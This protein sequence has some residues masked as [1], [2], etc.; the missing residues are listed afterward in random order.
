MHWSSVTSLFVSYQ[1]TPVL[2]SSLRGID[3]VFLSVSAQH[4]A[5]PLDLEQT[6]AERTVARQ[7]GDPRFVAARVDASSADDIATL[8][9]NASQSGLLSYRKIGTLIDVR[10]DHVLTAAEQELVR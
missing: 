9:A 10:F 4:H 2:Q 7:D 8:V 6:E 5:P 1:R 3:Y